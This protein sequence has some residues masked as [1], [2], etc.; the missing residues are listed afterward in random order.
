MNCYSTRPL[1]TKS[2]CYIFAIV[3]AIVVISSCGGGSSG[4]P[5]P[6]PPITATET[7]LYSFQGSNNGSSDGYQPSGGLLKDAAGNLY[8]TTSAGGGT[9]NWGTVFKLD[10][11]GHETVLYGFL[12]NNNFGN[13]GA[14]PIGSLIMDNTGNLFGTT[15]SG[16]D[17]IDC[18][19]FGGC[20]TIFKL[21]TSGNETVLYRF[22]GL[23]GD[24]ASPEGIISDG[25]GNLFGATF[26]GGFGILGPQCWCG[27][28]FQLDSAG[29][30][31]V[32]YSFTGSAT[33]GP[34]PGGN[35]VRDNL[36]NLY[37]ITSNGN[38]NNGLGCGV[39]FKLDTTGH[40]TVLHSF[41]NSPEGVP[42]SGLVMDS[43]GNLYGTTSDGGSSSSCPH[44]CGTIFKIDTSGQES[45]L[46]R[47]NGA[48]KQD[49]SVP[50][51][52]VV[53]AS[54]NLY[55]ITAAGGAYAN[56]P[57]YLSGVTGCGTFFKLDSTGHETVLYNFKGLSAQDGGAPS[58]LMM[59]AVGNFYGTTQI[60]GV[61]CSGITAGCGTVFKMTLH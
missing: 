45:L 10:V 23:N 42:S 55:G 27:T 43:T 47:F 8:G 44:G 28:V 26:R 5:P 11:S 19:N 13:D 16:G 31:T 59:D 58:N 53:D 61:A 50:V 33:D 17:Y 3:A 36:G 54:G 24:G 35:L 48:Q 38:C 51:A 22:T 32:L 14:E 30:E 41:S 40:E 56:C 37:G 34:P 6:P 49:G 4:G 29:T 15:V 18:G 57:S 20:G 1:N 60:G 2:I 12:G 25:V 9:R 7:L 21:D 52:L 46:Y 39:A